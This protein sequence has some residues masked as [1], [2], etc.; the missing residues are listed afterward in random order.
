MNRIRRR[1]GLAVATGGTLVAL[2]TLVIACTPPNPAA[3]HASSAPPVTSAPATV[4][5][6]P[7]RL[8]LTPTETPATSQSFS[9]L[10]GD[11]SHMAGQLQIRPSQGG[12]ARTYDAHAAAM[13]NDNPLRHFSTTV[14]GLHPAT[15]YN[16]RVGL[17]GS[18]SRWWEFSTADPDDSTFQFLY[19][20]DAQIGLDSAWPSV[21]RQAESMAPGSIGSV[22]AGDLID[23][24]RDETEWGNWFMGMGESAATRNVIA[25]PGTHEHIDDTRFAAWKANFEYPRNNPTIDTIGALADLA[26]GDSDVARQHAAYFR[27]WAETG[28]ET[29]YFSD[30]QSVRFITL[31]ATLDVDVLTPPG[32]PPCVDDDCP[33]HRVGELWAR[34]QAS[35]LDRVLTDSPAKWNVVTFH[36]P[37]YSGSPDRD[38]PVLRA[39]WVPVI[40]EHN[41]DLVLMG[42]DHVYVRGHHNDDLI[43]AGITDGPVYVISNSGAKHYQLTPDDRNVWT[44]NNA[45]QVR[46]GA[47]VTTYQVIDVSEDQ[48]VYRSY[49][50]DKSPDATTDLPI[51]SV[52]DEFVVTN[53]DDGRKWVTEAGIEPP[54]GARR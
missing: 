41:V 31:N 8:V 15:S 25:A 5:A 16:Y 6:A 37:V 24:A 20:G 18:W 53:T 11:P 7:T 48:L 42:H 1:V 4:V 38:E 26:A 46:R 40:E 10:A 49:L 50:A 47:G 39:H 13:V 51:G 29:V 27:Y 43:E 2:A 34:F 28:A 36:E 9:W 33:S 17:E 22:H 14:Q 52:F 23:G 45:T 12:D 19:Y 32:L 30:Y 35:W 21:V 44:V 3:P 54:I